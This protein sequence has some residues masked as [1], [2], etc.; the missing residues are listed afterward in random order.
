M[1]KLALVCLV[2]LSLSESRLELPA[3][4]FPMRKS[5]S[6]SLSGERAATGE[7]DTDTTRE[8]VKA[9]LHLLWRWRL[10]I[11]WIAHTAR[12]IFKNKTKTRTW[13]SDYKFHVMCCFTHSS[14]YF[15]AN[16]ISEKK[17]STPLVGLKLMI[18]KFNTKFLLKYNLVTSSIPGEGAGC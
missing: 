4:S 13:R 17:S 8:S 6:L 14:T 9:C 15:Q 3:A 10:H 12:L 7:P 1:C 2:F 11:C 18:W 5:L 16:L